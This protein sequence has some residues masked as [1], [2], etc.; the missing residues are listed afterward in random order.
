MDLVGNILIIAFTVA[1]LLSF[2]AAL[3]RCEAISGGGTHWYGVVP[4][5]SWFGRVIGGFLASVSVTAI[6]F[7]LCLA[8]GLLIH[9]L[10]QLII[11]FS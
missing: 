2:F 3:G 1:A 4:R 6:I 5:T 7:A 10:F 8:C 9:L 11:T